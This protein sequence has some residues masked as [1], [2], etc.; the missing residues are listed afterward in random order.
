MSRVLIISD[1]H[2]DRWE[3]EKRDPLSA[4]ADLLQGVDAVIIAGD[5]SDKPQKRWTRFLKS[6]KEMVGPVVPIHI[7]PGNHDFY[8]CRIDD[9]DRLKT[10]AE[11]AG[12]HY[13]Q[14]QVVVIGDTRF[15]CATLWTDYEGADPW[16]YQDRHRK[17]SSND[18]CYI[19][20]ASRGFQ[21]LRID[22]VRKIHRDHRR[23]LEEKLSEPW[24]GQTVMVTH[25]V[26]HL[27]LLAP[28]TGDLDDPKRMPCDIERPGMYAS[29]LSAIFEGPSAPDMAVYGHSHG[30]ADGIIG[31][32][33]MRSVSLGYPGEFETD[34]EIR[35]RFERA[36][37]EVG[38]APKLHP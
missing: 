36:I 28:I 32:T 37:F 21:P 1:L 15:L 10:F 12:A 16:M 11:E 17:G 7:I 26:P 38:P 14:K 35:A 27:S 29:D 4:A 8:D 22:D 5:L 30:A 3:R 6:I 19:R 34:T 9:E 33:Q 24:S 31:R 18:F 25:H 2:L 23:W 13:A 20:V